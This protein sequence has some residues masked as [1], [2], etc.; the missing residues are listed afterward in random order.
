[1][2]LASCHTRKASRH[3]RKGCLSQQNNAAARAAIE[4]LGRVLA[5]VRKTMLARGGREH[6]DRCVRDRSG[7]GGGPLKQSLAKKQAGRTL[8]GWDSEARR[9]DE[10]TTTFRI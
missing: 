10:Q 7:H 4:H 1:M 5:A 3:P 2:D 6:L 8:A 9:H